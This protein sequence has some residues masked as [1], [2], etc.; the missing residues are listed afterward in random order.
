[1][2]L[3][4]IMK[5]PSGLDQG[6]RLVWLNKA[7]MVLL[8]LFGK[9]LKLRAV[10]PIPVDSQAEFTGKTNESEKRNKN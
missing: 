2:D 8:S 6:R 3:I 9:T 4:F 5:G 1:M 7:R 10:M